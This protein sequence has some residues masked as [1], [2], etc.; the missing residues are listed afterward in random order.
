MR[1]HVKHL[2]LGLVLTLS[3][4]ITQTPVCAQNQT[5]QGN[6]SGVVN[7][8]SLDGQ[9]FLDAVANA[10]KGK[11]P[12]DAAQIV[13]EALNSAKGKTF[14]I[15]Q[16]TPNPEQGA[17]KNVKWA[18]Q[19]WQIKPNQS[20]E[21]G[22]PLATL[23][24]LPPNDKLAPKV[25]KSTAKG[26]FVMSKTEENSPASNLG[27]VEVSGDQIAVA[28]ALAAA[29]SNPKAATA[30]ATAAAEVFPSA[31]PAIAAT[32][33]RYLPNEASKIAT[34]LEQSLPAEKESIIDALLGEGDF[35]GDGSP[36]AMGPSISL[37]TG[38]GGGGSGG[39]GM[40]NN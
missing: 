10:V 20:V 7:F 16:V 23:V 5:G 13:K 3:F 14:R 1:R 31:A 9:A 15:N 19:S 32:M 40:Y 33:A 25:L 12:A 30:I 4:A 6:S 26:K 22:T 28:V 34:A 24:A 35:S 18:V 36:N 21:V 27:Y 17:S 11:N 37:P 8:K 29:Q 2:T 39:G 38:S